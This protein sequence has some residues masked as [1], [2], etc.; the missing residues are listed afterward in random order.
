MPSNPYAPLADKKRG[1]DPSP[2]RSASRSRAAAHSGDAVPPRRLPAPLR[3]RAAATELD[4][5]SSVIAADRSPL[6]RS[7][8][9]SAAA[10]ARGDD[11]LAACRRRRSGSLAGDD[12]RHPLHPSPGSCCPGKRRR[13]CRALPIG[14]FLFGD[15]TLQRPAAKPPSSRSMRTNVET[16]TLWRFAKAYMARLPR[17]ANVRQPGH[18]R[19]GAARSRHRRPSRRSCR[20]MC[21]G[22][23]AA[24]FST[25]SMPDP[26]A[27]ARNISLTDGGALRQSRS[28][29]RCGSAYAN[30]L[31]SDAGAALER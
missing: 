6:R 22:S 15:A 17:S 25:H 4:R 29:R 16:G 18:C 26:P 1:S 27:A 31:V 11:F 21:C 7:R 3:G 23:S 10:R 9:E 2:R 13:L 19:P 28:A 14:R 30:V 8:C 24:D 20:P 12:D 5:I